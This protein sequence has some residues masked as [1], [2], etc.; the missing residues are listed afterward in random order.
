MTK[1]EYDAL[2]IGQLVALKSGHLSY[3]YKDVIFKVVAKHALQIPTRL[4]IYQ[5]YKDIENS[6]LLEPSLA[7]F[8]YALELVPKDWEPRRAKSKT[9]IT[10]FIENENTICVLYQD[11]RLV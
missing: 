10:P 4:Y 2:N 8:A 6:C 9:M 3:E 7:S 11:A 5:E 1:H